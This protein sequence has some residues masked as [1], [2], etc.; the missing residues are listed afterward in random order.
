MLHKFFFLWSLIILLPA[1]IFAQTTGKIRGTVIDRESGDPLP[2]ANVSIVGTTLGAATD[3][4]GEFVILQVPVGV[5]KLK[6]SFIGFREVIVSNVKVSA[7]LTTRIDFQLPSEALEV[8]TVEIVAERP[9]VNQSATNA[10]RIQT[11]ESIEKLPLRGLTSAFALQPGVV[12]QNGEL[13][14]RGGRADEVGYMVEG[15]N[16]RNIMNGDNAVFIIPEALEEFQIQAGGYNAEFGG[17]NAGI[18]TQTIRS[19]GNEYHA[20]LQIETDEWPGQSH[21]EQVLDTFSYGY[22]DYTLTLG[23]PVLKN[24]I[25][26]FVALNRQHFDDSRRVFWKG[27][28][29]R[30]VIGNLIDEDPSILQT[31]SNNLLFDENGNLVRDE[32][33]NPIIVDSGERGGRPG[34]IVP[35]IK[36]TD[37]NIDDFSNQQSLNAS[38]NFDYNPILFRFTLSST[39]RRDELTGA[40][41]L[42]NVL[43]SK[44]FGREERSTDLF[45]AKLTHFLTKNLFYEVN[46]NLFDNRRRQFDPTFGNNYLLYADSLAVAEKLGPEFASNFQAV[47]RLPRNYDVFKFPFTRPGD[48]QTLYFK[49]KQRYASVNVDVTLQSRRH[50]VKFGGSFERWTIRRISNLGDE[51]SI[52]FL[53]S[54][55][56][57]ARA[58]RNGPSDPLF[59]RAVFAFRRSNNINAFGYDVLGNEVDDDSKL[60]DGPKHP[61]FGALYLQDKFEA[62]DLVIN[63]GFR[64]DFFDFDQRIPKNLANPEFDLQK[65]DIPQDALRSTDTEVEFSPRVG[66]AF[67]VTDRTVFHVQYGR[68]VQAPQFINVF[69]GRAIQAL[70]FGAGNFVPNP[71][72]AKELDPVVTVQYEIGFNQ[73]LT[74]F[75][76][77]D[78]TAFLRDVKGQLQV[79]KQITEPGAAAGAF[80]IFQNQDFATTKGVELSLTLRRIQRIS[81]F[82]SYTFSDAQGTGSFPN[83]SVGAVEVESQ[84]PTIVSP[85]DFNQRHRGSISFDYRFGKGDGGPILERLGLNLLFTFNSGHPFTRAGGGIAQQG[86]D[87]GGILNN[88]DPRGRE[89]LEDVNAST[90][91]WVA[92]LDLRVD[93]TITFGPVD[94]NFYFYVQNVFDSKNVLEVYQRT[95]TAEDDGFLTNPEL[96]GDIVAG[97]GPPYVALYKLINLAD[98]QHQWSRNGFN[99]DLFGTPR[100]FRFGLSLEY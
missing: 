45:T 43:N 74:D 55:P 67:P 89:P 94:V 98:R 64:L 58:L 16:A 59:E 31:N 2:G 46:F 62:G 88:L 11:L 28:D 97:A 3:I 99:R 95:G 87:L 53:R 92:N 20:R 61:K 93:K 22:Q 73:A 41:P 47:D 56:D 72:V 26:A 78:I 15:A 80:N 66:V 91:P 10:V 7:G 70:I 18:V 52:Q 84:I 21:G 82:I 24:R 50:E 100:Q 60:F 32:N 54:Q 57:L 42:L 49:E 83:S 29:L 38:L 90:T 1:L 33:G 25:K 86:P 71:Q 79:T 96:S 27:F 19:G 44:R 17:A 5:Y 68:F 48:L 37:G 65:F 39:F 30:E 12:F 76:A 85:L 36:I 4:N 77:F 75:A 69:S 34:E 13:Y 9:L 40:R 81:A 14:I 63:A 51:D 6:A 35:P 8:G 23:G